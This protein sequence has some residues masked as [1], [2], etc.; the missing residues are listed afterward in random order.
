MVRAAKVKKFGAAVDT[1]VELVESLPNGTLFEL[2]CE[3][4]ANVGSESDLSLGAAVKAEM[5]ELLVEQL[6]A[7][8]MDI[9]SGIDRA[10]EKHGGLSVSVVARGMAGA[11]R[12]EVLGGDT[13]EAI[14]AAFRHWDPVPV[15]DAIGFEMATSEQD[16]S[17]F[18]QAV[19]EARLDYERVANVFYHPEMLAL[20]ERFG[21]SK[22]DVEREIERRNPFGP[23][24]VVHAN[25]IIPVSVSVDCE[26]CGKH[27]RA[28]PDMQGAP[29]DELPADA[30]VFVR[31][32]ASICAECHETYQDSR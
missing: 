30:R 4:N 6:G 15:A 11:G 29:V 28:Y 14:Q 27:L 32:G 9:E 24:V 13:V 7:L 23:K 12:D 19:L 16:D 1:A 2:K 26:R 31:G 3:I 5:D 22:E 21:L 8:G 17:G 20:A 18:D 10:V 25:P